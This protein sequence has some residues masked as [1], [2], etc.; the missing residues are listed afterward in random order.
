MSSNT[1]S[2]KRYLS[3]RF[4][5][6]RVRERG[7]VW[8]FK[9]AA[10]MVF[11]PVCQSPVVRRTTLI[12]PSLRFLLRPDVQPEKRILAIMDL[13]FAPHSYGEALTFQEVT[14]IERILHGVDKIDI[15][16]LC[17]P[18]QP[19][20]D[21]QRLTT[22]NYYYYL[23]DRLP[24]AYVNP[25]LGSFFL[26]DSGEA[27]EAYIRDNAHRY[28]V[29]PSFQEY[30]GRR[31]IYRNYFNRVQEFYHQHGYIPNLSCQADMVTWARF[32]IK[33]EVRPCLPV[34]VHL[35][36]DRS[37]TWGLALERNVKLDYW[38]E[39]FAFCKDKFD[40]KFIVV[41]GKDE[42]D[43][44]FRNLT[45]V[46]LSKDY[47]TTVEQ[48][49]ALIQVSMMFMGACSGIS[50]MAMFSEIPYI[51]VNFRPDFED[52]PYGSSPAFVTSRQ[53]LIWEPETTE[54]LIDEFQNLFRQ[55][56]TSQWERDFDRLAHDS[57]TKL[58]RRPRE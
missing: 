1:T 26:M 28:Y 55:L 13:R 58:S 45:N 24:L 43:P 21:D 7:I 40:V 33:E 32:F 18:N 54:L 9:A 27:L 48:E 8:C 11:Q 5:A 41:C 30:L 14:M 39:F 16:W 3:P 29:F 23:S 46:I 17:D 25:H 2:W 37:K 6:G 31:W 49:L 56:D 50:A 38:L 53:R 4:L 34:V 22:D 12:I 35:R 20:R 15:V 52:I 57:N 19:A 10:G 47:A 51:I 36:N 44:R 42:I